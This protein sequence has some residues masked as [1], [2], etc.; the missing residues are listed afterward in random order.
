VGTDTQ[1]AMIDALGEQRVIERIWHHDHTVWKP[2]PAEIANR[3]GWLD[4]P[5]AMEDEQGGLRTFAERA[6]ERGIR[7]VYLLGMGG[8]SLAPEMYARVFG[9]ASGFPSLT[10]VDTTDPTAIRRITRGLDPDACLFLVATKS[11]TT[12]ETLSLCR[13][14]YTR[15]A[16]AIDPAD[17]GARFVAITDPG[18]PLEPLADRLGFDATFLND[19][20][21][22][23]R[24]SA[25]SH[26]GLV[27]AALL[28]IDL[29]ALL[30]RALELRERCGPSVPP[31]DHP[32]ARL[33]V[34]LADRARNG[35]D[36]LTFLLPPEIQAF[37]DWVE[38][39]IAESTGKE[40]KGI[41]PVVTE[42]IGP[43]DVYGFDRQFVSLSL[44]SAAPRRDAIDALTHVGHPLEPLELE[45]RYDLGAQIFLWEFAVAI[46]GH[47][48]A[49]NPFD[50][51]NVEQSKRL[52]RDMVAAFRETGSLPA[53]DE[54]DAS[55]GAIERFSAGCAP[56]EYLSIH[57]YLPPSAAL[58][59]ALRTLGGWL[60]DAT[61]CATT[62][63]FGP[64][65]LHSTGQLHKGDAGR[66]RFLQLL[67]ADPHDVPIPDVAGRPDASMTFGVLKEAQARGDAQ[68]LRDAGRPVH[69]IQLGDAPEDA[70][71]QLLS[72]LGAAGGGASNDVR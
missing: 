66:G 2:D 39:L 41:L 52:A 15:L 28:G 31:G 58:R 30:G 50:Q 57:A 21:L 59:R 72:G 29:D 19:P 6:R 23:G 11:G 7:E 18:S 62:V 40:G 3:L 47:L 55:V 13:H 67:C 20:H 1:G 38:Q 54:E 70:L 17:V 45:A 24:Y 65:F 4:C 68:A 8:S 49:I 35:R 46:V 26:F 33:G 56:G 64:R 42:P 22:G 44:P 43:V 16:G 48:L 9:A 61:H 53:M 51:P 71:E 5:V 10:V 34:K 63:A 36:K 25:L 14:F 69:R 37:G 60:R 32:A 12:T 27:P